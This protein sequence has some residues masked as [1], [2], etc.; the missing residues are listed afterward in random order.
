MFKPQKNRGALAAILSLIYLICGFYIGCDQN[1]KSSTKK[2]ATT[3]PPAQTE[4]QRQE[5]HT[6]S[7]KESESEKNSGK[8][9]SNNKKTTKNSD[10]DDDDKKANPNSK[11]SNLSGGKKISLSFSPAQTKAICATDVDSLYNLVKKFANMDNDD[12]KD[13]SESKAGNLFSTSQMKDLKSV[14]SS[15]KKSDIAK[16][17]ADVCKGQSSSNS[18][19]KDDDEENDDDDNRDDD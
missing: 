7:T 12:L 10:D 15:L 9:S 18:K 17:K 1:K 14:A 8:N 3:T 13:L 6:D 11:K 16:F 2:S 4:T 5:S 19:N